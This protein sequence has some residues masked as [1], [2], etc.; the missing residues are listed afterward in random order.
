MW[1]TRA[2]RVS[3]IW[4]SLP[5]DD[6]HSRVAATNI[7]KLPAIDLNKFRNI[8]IWSLAGS[9][10]SWLFDAALSEPF[11]PLE[12]VVD[13]DPVFAVGSVALTLL[14]HSRR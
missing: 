2:L 9:T 8:L 11:E 10:F 3:L 6:V 13:E 14:V 5:I 12:S 1:L 7:P 4:Y